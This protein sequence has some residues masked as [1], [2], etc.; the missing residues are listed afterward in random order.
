M[1]PT[2][3]SGLSFLAVP[4]FPA[5]CHR[6]GAKSHTRIL[7]VLLFAVGLVVSV[8]AAPSWQPFDAM[9]PKRV[10][11][12]YMENMTS[13]DLSLHVANIDPT[14][15]IFKSIITESSTALSLSETPIASDINDDIPD[16]DIV[17][18]GRSTSPPRNKLKSSAA[19]LPCQPISAVIQGSSSGASSWLR[20]ALRCQVPGRGCRITAQRSHANALSQ[21]RNPASRGYLDSNRLYCR[22][23]QLG[24]SI[25]A[26]ARSS[27]ASCERSVGVRHRYLGA[28]DDDTIARQAI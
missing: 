9:H 21:A 5:L 22:C 28:R 6:W 2:I 27:P 26:G 14:S 1:F 13:N 15:S 18:L 11:C 16:W 3:V 12:L 19:D 25:C 8:F 20:I 24:P 7:V 10:L 23:H 4:T 17:S